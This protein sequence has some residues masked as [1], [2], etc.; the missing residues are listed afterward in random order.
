LPQGNIQ[1]LSIEAVS[2]NRVFEAEALIRREPR[3]ETKVDSQEVDFEFAKQFWALANVV[4]G[5]S[6]AQLVAFG[7]AAASAAP[8][9]HLAASSG[10]D[11]QIQNHFGVSLTFTIISAFAPVGLVWFCQSTCKK[12][13]SSLPQSSATTKSLHFFDALRFAATVIAG[14]A[15]IGLIISIKFPS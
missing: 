11:A 14:A 1:R 13:M 15:S 4:V 3:L 2:A 8:V 9:G 5:F 6:I 12:I 7:I 10:L